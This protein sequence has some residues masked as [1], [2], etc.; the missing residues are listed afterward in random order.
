VSVPR[1]PVQLLSQVSQ[2]MRR[3]HDLGV[4]QTTVGNWQRIARGQ[5][6]TYAADVAR[7]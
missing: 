6:N 1:D 2:M 5:D 3:M 7:R 4:H